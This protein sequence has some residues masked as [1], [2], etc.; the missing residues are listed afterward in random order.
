MAHLT[1]Q[2]RPAAYKHQLSMTQQAMLGEGENVICHRRQASLLVSS[3][4]TCINTEV[5]ANNLASLM[6]P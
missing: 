1:P 3:P 2:P 6:T 5:C 4:L